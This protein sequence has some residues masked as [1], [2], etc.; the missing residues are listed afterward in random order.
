MFFLGST[1]SDIGLKNLSIFFPN[2]LSKSFNFMKKLL[3]MFLKLS[4]KL[5]LSPCKTVVLNLFSI[6]SAEEIS[7]YYPLI[8]PK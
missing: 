4:F 6:E 3:I 1:I 8:Q 2:H 5:F 7:K